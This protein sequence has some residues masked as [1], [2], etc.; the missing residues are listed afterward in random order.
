MRNLFAHNYGAVD[1]ERV[2]ETVISDIPQLLGFCAQTIQKY[3]FLE[4]EENEAVQ[5]EYEMD[6]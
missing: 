5:S 1:I 2:W 3:R 4:Q 6:S